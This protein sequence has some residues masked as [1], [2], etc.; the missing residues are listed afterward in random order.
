MITRKLVF[1]QITVAV[2]P[3][4]IIPAWIFWRATIRAPRDDT[5]RCTVI[6]PRS[7]HH[8]ANA[9]VKPRLTPARPFRDDTNVQKLATKD[10]WCTALGPSVVAFG[11]FAST[12]VLRALIVG[13]SHDSVCHCRVHVGVSALAGSCARVPGAVASFSLEGVVVSQGAHLIGNRKNAASGQTVRNKPLSVRTAVAVLV[14]LTAAAIGVVPRLDVP[15]A[16]AS[17]VTASANNLRNGW[18]PNEPGLSPSVVAG[19]SFGE[20]FSTPVNGQV[21][22][23]PIVAGSTVIVATENDWVY[24]LDAV[25]GAVKWSLSLGAPWPA[26]SENCFDLAPN[27]GVTGT[28]VYDASTGTVY[29]VA[30][31]VPPGNPSSQPAFYMHALNAQTGAE[32][33]GWPV[34]IQGAPV[35]DPTRPFTPFTEIERPA[36][37]E[38]GGSV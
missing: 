21:Y 32:L 26:S 17:E 4:W 30:K 28:P 14:G 37:L 16:R 7:G 9:Q 5:R 29:M 1:S 3:A 8:P 24:G 36:L 34:Q 6:G 27:V 13:H 12:V 10:R 20:L 25:T 15:T 33:P 19:G 11:F 38:L 31:V 22:A 2:L 23:Q 18:D 35:N